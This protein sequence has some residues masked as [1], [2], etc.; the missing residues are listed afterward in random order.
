[1]GSKVLLFVGGFVLAVSL[2]ACSPSPAGVSPSRPVETPPASSDSTAPAAGSRL[3]PGLYELADG[4]AQAIGVLEYRD[5]E[6]GTWVVVGTADLYSTK[7][8]EA[9]AVIANP[10]EFETQLKQLRGQLVAVTGT[11]ADGA[12]IR[13]AGPEIKVKSI[14]AIRDSGGVAE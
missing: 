10:N 2:A 3:A 7:P 14:E 12:S 6:G 13:M 9:I 11:K 8:A 4:S 5:V 1:M